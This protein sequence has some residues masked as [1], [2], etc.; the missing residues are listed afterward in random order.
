MEEQLIT[1]LISLLSA[2][3][4]A[5]ITYF[6]TIRSNQNKQSEEV[7]KEQK[8]KY[9]LPFKDCSIE[10][11][12]R[13]RHIEARIFDEKDD[14]KAHFRQSF[15][16][17]S[18]EWYHVDWVNAKEM[19][20]GGYFL[21]STIYMNCLLYSKIK[22]IQQ[23]YPFILLRL[24]Y[25]L[26]DL[27]KS[28]NDLQIRRCFDSVVENKAQHENLFKQIIRLVNCKREISIKQLIIAIRVSTIMNNGIPYSL[29]NSFGDYVMKENKEINYYDFC[30]LLKNEKE[31]IKFSTIT[32][33]WIKLFDE[34]GAIDEEK[35]NRLRGLI[36]ILKLV[37]NSNLS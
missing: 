18:D 34:N 33:F 36:V 30:A 6:V 10:F 31:M 12:H 8:Y 7:K 23:E 3:I 21:T 1:V 22:L 29:H 28:S 19:I 26:N 9:F 32:N 14:M 17:K 13:L 2:V 27:L 4:T 25:T 20:P 37:T 35:L 5:V 16:D 11:L 15:I 24:K